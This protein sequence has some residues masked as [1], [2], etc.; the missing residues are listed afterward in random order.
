[1]AQEAEK[2]EPENGSRISSL[3]TDLQKMPESPK[4]LR[5]QITKEKMTRMNTERAQAFEIS[6]HKASEEDLMR[7]IGFKK[8]LEK[9]AARV[10]MIKA[11]KLQEQRRIAGVRRGE[12]TVK[13]RKKEA[14]EQKSPRISSPRRSSPREAKQIDA[15]PSRGLLE[16]LHDSHMRRLEEFSKSKDMV[17][18]NELEEEKYRQKLGLSS[19]RIE[20]EEAGA[21][22]KHGS[23]MGKETRSLQ[24]PAP[25]SKRMGVRE[26]MELS[27]SNQL[28]KRDLKK[29]KR[30]RWIDIQRDLHWERHNRNV[31]LEALASHRLAECKRRVRDYG[32]SIRNENE[33]RMRDH[34]DRM[35]EVEEQN[36]SLV[37]EQFDTQEASRIANERN[38]ES[39]R[40]DQ[41]A[42]MEDQREMFYAKLRDIARM[43]ALEIQKKRRKLHEKERI[44]T[45]R[46][47]QRKAEQMDN[48]AEKTA[49]FNQKVDL[50]K[51]NK[52]NFDLAF[53]Q[54][55]SMHLDHKFSRLVDMS[56][57][58]ARSRL[59]RAL[60]AGPMRMSRSALSFPLEPLGLSPEWN[61]NEEEL[62]AL[63]KGGEGDETKQ[64]LDS[65]E[66][67]IM[68]ALDE[69][70]DEAQKEAFLAE[71]QTQLMKK[72][73]RP[74]RKYRK[75]DISTGMGLDFLHLL[76]DGK[77][78]D[79][80][81]QWTLVHRNLSEVV[82]EEKVFAELA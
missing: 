24:L 5:A 3:T 63:R 14:E 57:L 34:H 81:V 33:E 53:R 15:V 12:A 47:I 68:A 58:S 17:H 71:V 48:I 32:N 22:M 27:R 54:N 61:P 45:E 6:S 64:P 4:K 1:M 31:E 40:L 80:A 65:D 35:A 55:T 74:R 72:T 41:E 56:S 11:L 29:D 18:R 82:S 37:Q 60:S 77:T 79:D 9:V 20:M 49:E 66:E 36:R 38:M 10:R 44:F 52:K 67:L 73:R 28:Y 7:R 69:E 62:E 51:S 8:K 42:R 25:R 50:C 43:H 19:G 78:T 75:R 46:M 59:V 16:D 70:M 2:K 39:K 13:Q 26:Q 23:G 30:S 76:N 21:A